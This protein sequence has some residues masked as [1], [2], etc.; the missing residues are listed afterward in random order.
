MALRPFEKNYDNPAEKAWR[1]GE[2][3]YSGNLVANRTAD[4]KRKPFSAEVR[5]NPEYQNCY[6]DRTFYH[7]ASQ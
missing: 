6:S 5:K 2:S 4:T 7:V 1:S 3:P